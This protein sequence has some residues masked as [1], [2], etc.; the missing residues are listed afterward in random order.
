MMK[1]CTNNSQTRRL[2][3][4]DPNKTVSGKPRLIQAM[5]NGILIVA[6]VVTACSMNSPSSTK[7]SSMPDELEKQRLSEDVEFSGYA[8]SWED[9]IE[10]YQFPF[11]NSRKFPMEK[12]LG[13]LFY[14]HKQSHIVV[15]HISENT[16]LDNY[17]SHI[18]F[19]RGQLHVLIK[20]GGK[21]TDIITTRNNVIFLWE[22]GD[23][24]GIKIKKNEKDMVDFI[25]HLSVPNILTELYIHFL[26]NPDGYQVVNQPDQTYKKLILPQEMVKATDGIVELYVDENDFW[27][28]GGMIINEEITLEK[29][30]PS[31][32]KP[33]I[34]RPVEYDELPEELQSIDHIEFIE[35][36]KTL[37]NFIEYI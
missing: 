6:F 1:R 18:Y 33:I 20:S 34:E 9:H 14:S 21:I 27:L 8:N 28:Y 26:E 23:K 24:T 36:D 19:K 5:K 17:E 16:I 12:L 22:D 25:V 3:L 35:S 37:R 29:G 7:P 10:R 11:T 30:F 4:H 31:S 32:F 2:W 13:N 15:K